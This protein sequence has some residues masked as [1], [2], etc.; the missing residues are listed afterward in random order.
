[1]THILFDGFYP[2]VQLCNP[3]VEYLKSS[4]VNK[5]LEEVRNILPKFKYRLHDDSDSVPPV[6]VAA[7]VVDVLFLGQLTRLIWSPPDAPVAATIDAG[8]P[9]ASME[10]KHILELSAGEGWRN[11]AS[12]AYFGM[13]ASLISPE[14]EGEMSLRVNNKGFFHVIPPEDSEAEDSDEF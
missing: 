14:K 4:R 1:M 6:E 13:G 11:S 10:W 2:Q 3:F 9:E 8:E 12:F 5:G 7:N